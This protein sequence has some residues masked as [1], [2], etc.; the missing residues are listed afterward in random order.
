MTS[1][2]RATKKHVFMVGMV[3]LPFNVSP[4]IL[5]IIISVGTELPFLQAI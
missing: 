5:S 3:L 1:M 2:K 4:N